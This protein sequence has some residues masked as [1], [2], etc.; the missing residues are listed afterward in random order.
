MNY[1]KTIL[2]E[3]NLKKYCLKTGRRLCSDVS[4]LLTPQLL[5][6]GLKLNVPSSHFLIPFSMNYRIFIIISLKES[7][8][9][10]K[11]VECLM[12][13]LIFYSMQT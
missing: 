5:K 1:F 2:T 9:C 10:S 6:L 4:K 8:P 11:K 12:H 7:L 13:C 3:N